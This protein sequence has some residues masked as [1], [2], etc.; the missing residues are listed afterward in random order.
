MFWFFVIR[1]LLCISAGPLY[2]IGCFTVLYIN[3]VL[4]TISCL[5]GFA[6]IPTSIMIQFQND[7][8]NRS[9]NQNVRFRC[10]HE[11][12]DALYN[13]LINGTASTHYPDVRVNSVAESN[14]TFVDTLTIP[15]IPAYNGTEVVCVATFTDGSPTERTPPVMLII[16]GWIT[17]L[18]YLYMYL[19]LILC[20]A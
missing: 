8:T 2:I 17:M 11:R 3:Y 10:R 18:Y 15:A 9:A 4:E 5:L 14:G 6:E 12:P 13:W 1:C 20:M 19:S 7:V 16:T